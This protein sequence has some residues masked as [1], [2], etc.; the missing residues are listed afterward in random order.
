MYKRKY[1][2]K[3]VSIKRT[4]HHKNSA[5]QASKKSIKISDFQ[6]NPVRSNKAYISQFLVLPNAMLIHRA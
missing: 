2:K 6:Y 4:Q 3:Y 1:L 5:A